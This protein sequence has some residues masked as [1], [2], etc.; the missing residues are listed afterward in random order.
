VEHLIAAL[1]DPDMRVEAKTVDVLGELR[2]TD[3]TVVLI[4]HL[5]LRTTEPQM[6]QR[7][8]AALGK[9]GDERAAKP[10][11]EFL[12][13]DLD[14]ATRGTAIYALGDIGSPDALETLEQLGQTDSDPTVR[15]LA[16][17]A[18]NKVRLHQSAVSKEVKAAETFLPKAPPEP[19]E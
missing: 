5:F 19:E 4:Q 18:A 11:V 8:L 12:Q 1:G 14:S 2:A 15:R 9:I 17:E 3:A 7:I 6:K 10:I 13:R 16:Y